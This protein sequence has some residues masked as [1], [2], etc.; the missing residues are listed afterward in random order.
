MEWSRPKQQSLVPGPRAGHAGATI[1]E[2]WYIV[3]GGDNKT[4]TNLWPMT[5]IYL[6]ILILAFTSLLD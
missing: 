6:F 2:S 4:G 1:G 5:F 3:G